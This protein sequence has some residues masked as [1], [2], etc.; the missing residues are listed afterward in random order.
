M[1]FPRLLALLIFAVACTADEAEDFDALLENGTSV[2]ARDKEE[3]IVRHFFRDRRDGVFVDVGCYLPRQ[4]NVTYYL[5]EQL[6]WSG[7]AVDALA[8]FGPLWAEARPRSR[9]FAYAV[10]DRSGDTIT[11]HDAGPISAIERTTIDR[12]AEIKGKPIPTREIQIPTITLDDLLDRAGVTRI[13]FFKIDVNGAEPT[14]MAGFDIQR[15]RPELVHV[16]VHPQNRDVL[17]RYFAEN[18]YRRID[19]YL[20]YDSTNWY[21]TPRD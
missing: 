1:R 10:T 11:F 19:A 15:F 18:S 12:W 7:I 8:K 5:E 14:A 21:F 9:F 3:L 17:S 13:D 16:E 6:N 20:E 4:F 2:Y